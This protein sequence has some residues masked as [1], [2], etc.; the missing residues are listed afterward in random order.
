MLNP[1]SYY[2]KEAINSKV[3]QIQTT[4]MAD[5]KNPNFVYSDKFYFYSKEVYL[6]Q[7]KINNHFSKNLIT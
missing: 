3:I 4:L 1:F 2:L 6:N 5:H 7:I